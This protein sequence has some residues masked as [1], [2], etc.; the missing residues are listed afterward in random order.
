M[1]S[2]NDNKPYRDY[3]RQRGPGVGVPLPEISFNLK[4]PKHR[5]IRGFIAEV[6]VL[7]ALRKEHRA[8]IYGLGANFRTLSGAGLPVLEHIRFGDLGLLDEDKAH[9]IADVARGAYGPRPDFLVIIEEYE[10]KA[11]V[12]TELKEVRFVEVKSRAGRRSLNY[13]RELARKCKEVG[14]KFILAVVEF[15]DQWKLNIKFKEA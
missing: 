1:R 4:D 10:V 2:L 5:D 14:V 11:G 9:L 13:S 6:A 7:W 8:R 12:K 3:I 15:Q